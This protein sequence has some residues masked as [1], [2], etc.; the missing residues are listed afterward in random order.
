MTDTVYLDHNATTPVLPAV[1]QAMGEALSIGGNASST[2]ARGR[3]TRALIEAARAGLAEAIGADREAVV[4]TSGGSEANAL[5][6]GGARVK[7][8]V[9]S[10]VEHDSVAR[11]VADA[12]I[13]PVDGDGRV[14]LEVLRRIL[15]SAPRE[16]LVSV[17]M[18]N[19]ETGVIQPIHA[20]RDLVREHGALLH[21]DA[22]QA[23]GKMAIDFHDLGADFL[24]LSAHKF[25]GPQGVGALVRRSGAP[26]GAVLRGGGQ[27]FGLRAGTENLAGIVGMGRAAEEID[28]R[29]GEMNRLRGFRDRLEERIRAINPDSHIFGAGVPRL[30]NTSCVTLPGIEAETQ[31]MALDLAGVMVGAGSACSSG[32][33][34]E[35]RVLRAMGASP[36]EARSAIRVS[37]GPQNREE[38]LDRFMECWSGLVKRSQER[39]RSVE[40]RSA[41]A[42]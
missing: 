12:Q 27:E 36:D 31:V 23:V 5:A 11:A 3:A 29:I 2:H 39:R 19:N 10:A 4:F 13:I 8:V 9:A 6:L 24:S 40:T 38:D 28:A 33:I 30:A 26:L 17:M 1:I 42:A 18:A 41:T 14:D 16:T 37:F 35:S 21:V 34:T 20:V 22:I 7:H 25:G 15:A 32:K